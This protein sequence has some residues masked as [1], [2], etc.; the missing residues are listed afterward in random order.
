MRNVLIVT[1][2][3]TIASVSGH[4]PLDASTLVGNIPQLSDYANVA[5]EEH[6]GIGSSKMTHE[7]WLGLAK[8]VNSVLNDNSSPDGIVIT[9][10][11]D[12]LEEAAFFLNLTVKS[13][14]PVILTGAMRSADDE[15]PDGPLNLV[16][17]VRIAADDASIGQGVLVT[18]DEDVFAARDLTKSH[19]QRTGAFT[20]SR[21]GW[22]GF[23]DSRG[24]R[25][26]YKST[27]PHTVA[28]EFDVSE[29]DVLPKVSI[30]SDYVGFEA[31]S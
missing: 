12:T 24:V 6:C 7:I 28:S 29:L 31:G 30:L 17:A 19:N 21:S 4:E 16:N 22:V 2:G 13:S 8:R 9:H 26:Q 11:T 10:G 1:T 20:I 18:L 27:I 14:K 25:F 23:S 15:W 3:G 5:Y